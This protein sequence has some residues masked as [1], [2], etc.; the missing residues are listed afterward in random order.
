MPV[1][2]QMHRMVVAEALTTPELAA[3][4]NQAGPDQTRDKLRRFF[5]RPDVVA[6]LRPDVPREILPNHLLNCVLGDQLSRLMST[7]FE[8][9]DR[10]AMEK[11]VALGLDLFFRSVLR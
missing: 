2:L 7:P 8:A 10:A 11:Q 9:P 5:A 4:F 1:A 3:A 6:R